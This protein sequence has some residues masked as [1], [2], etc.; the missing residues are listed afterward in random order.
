MG[1]STQKHSHSASDRNRHLRDLFRAELPKADWNLA[2]IVDNTCIDNV[3]YRDEIWN[4]LSSAQ[5]YGLSIYLTFITDPMYLDEIRIIGAA[6]FEKLPE[7]IATKRWI[8]N[9]YFQK[10]HVKNDIAKFIQD[11]DKYRMSD[12]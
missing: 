12:A 1:L 10:G 3:W 4:I 11:L 8:T 5:N 6:A 9:R 7:D 2:K